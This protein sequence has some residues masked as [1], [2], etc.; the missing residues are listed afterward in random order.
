MSRK[1]DITETEHKKGEK[2]I[3]ILAESSYD[4]E[5]GL[6]LYPPQPFDTLASAK[7]QLAKEI[8]SL[9]ENCPDVTHV[10]T[11]EANNWE[12]ALYNDN[13]W[14]WTITTREI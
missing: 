12:Y 13:I 1:H 9:I 5:N 10:E 11:H 2:T 4:K 7:Q 8:G 14:V 6:I 3:Y